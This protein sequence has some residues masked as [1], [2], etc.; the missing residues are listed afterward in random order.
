MFA[1][2]AAKFKSI[3]GQASILEATTDRVV[4]SNRSNTHLLDLSSPKTQYFIGQATDYDFGGLSAV[5]NSAQSTGHTEINT[6][7]MKWQDLQGNIIKK[8]LCICCRSEDGVKVNPKGALDNFLQK[9][10][11][12]DSS[13][14]SPNREHCKQVIAEID[15][16][17]SEYMAINSNRYLMPSDVNWVNVATV[18]QAEA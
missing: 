11:P 16:G 7:I 14:P 3:L 9:P 15:L 10:L 8:Q 4:A 6:S 1:V 13:L 5:I 2:L 18:T 12:I 17:L